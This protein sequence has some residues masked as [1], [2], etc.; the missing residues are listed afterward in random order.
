MKMTDT[1]SLQPHNLLH[2]ITATVC[3]SI[4]RVSK[5][6][7]LGHIQITPTIQ[8]QYQQILVDSI[9]ITNERCQ[10]K[11]Q[12]RLETAMSVS[13][14]FLKYVKLCN[15]I[16]VRYDRPS[17]ASKSA[18]ASQQMMTFCLSIDSSSVRPRGGR[19]GRRGI[20]WYDAPQILIADDI[21]HR[22]L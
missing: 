5:N 16:S 4:H 18:T 21:M 6:G 8:V 15:I 10:R 1:K 2:L 17:E 9:T 12:V 3:I 13:L 14:N 11:Q 19:L 22:T 20:S 7:P